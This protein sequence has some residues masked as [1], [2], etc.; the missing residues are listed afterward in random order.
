MGQDYGL[1]RN[2]TEYWYVHCVCVCVCVCVWERERDKETET[3][4]Y[5][6]SDLYYTDRLNNQNGA[7]TEHFWAVFKL[8]LQNAI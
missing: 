5:M 7:F 4:K 3:E 8:N 2:V 1:C 6:L